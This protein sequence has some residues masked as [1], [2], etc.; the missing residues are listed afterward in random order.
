VCKWWFDR[1]RRRQRKWQKWRS[2]SWTLPQRRAKPIVEYWRA[3]LDICSLANASSAKPTVVDDTSRS[4][5]H[6]GLYCVKNLCNVIAGFF[7]NI[8]SVLCWHKWI[9][10]RVVCFQNGWNFTLYVRWR[11]MLQHSGTPCLL[12]VWLLTWSGMIWQCLP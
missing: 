1:C 11:C 2:A 3:N 6:F 8:R 7:T 12:L 4:L 5:N 10:V 9:M